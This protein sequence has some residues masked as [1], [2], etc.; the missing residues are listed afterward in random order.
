MH[1]SPTDGPVKPGSPSAAVVSAQKPVL[2]A[3]A[4]KR[5]PVRSSSMDAA[6]PSKP[7][8]PS[9]PDV[10]PQHKAEIL[11]KPEK[12][13][14]SEG[15][16]EDPADTIARKKE[17]EATLAAERAYQKQLEKESREDQ[18]ARRKEERDEQREIRKE[19]RDFD[20]VRR[21]EA[22]QAISDAV[23][24]KAM[25]MADLQKILV[26]HYLGYF[27]HFRVALAIQG[28]C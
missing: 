17:E 5:R 6:N 13:G 7:S 21:K 23:K 27:F 14:A 1:C 12:A 22:R 26:S 10:T 9:K 3:A 28:M 15:L 20:A 19:K 16:K 25:S 4:P 2:G 11:P 18:L 8:K 24:T